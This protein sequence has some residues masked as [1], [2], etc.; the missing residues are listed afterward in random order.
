M[1]RPTLREE[2]ITYLVFK[3]KWRSQ[4]VDAHLSMQGIHPAE[5]GPG[6]T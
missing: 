5:R 3:E 1:L 6:M 2:F 4:S